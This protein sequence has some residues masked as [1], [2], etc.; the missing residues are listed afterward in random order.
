[1]LSTENQGFPLQIRIL[2]ILSGYLSYSTTEEALSS[3]RWRHWG[4][5]EGV[6]GQF[7]LWP[8]YQSLSGAPAAGRKGTGTVLE[9][10]NHPT[11]IPTHIF[12]EQLLSIFAE[13]MGMAVCL[14]DLGLQVRKG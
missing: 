4:H 13:E 11:P 2:S 7:A 5:K 14:R 9:P 6:L 3:R 10:L 1:M 12:L 8:S